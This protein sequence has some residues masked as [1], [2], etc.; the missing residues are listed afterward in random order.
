VQLAISGVTNGQAQIEFFGTP[1]QQQI[2]EVSSN[3]MDWTPIA[4][5]TFVTNFFQLNTSNVLQFPSQFYRSII[6]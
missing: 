4:T 1:G 5:N 6:P 3:L 2:I